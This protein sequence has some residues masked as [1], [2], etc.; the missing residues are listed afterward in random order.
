M[1]LESEDK[2]DFSLG[3]GPPRPKENDG[4][5]ES[6]VAAAEGMIEAFKSGNAKQLARML[7]ESRKD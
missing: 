2:L 4:P 6:E 5:S 3:F 1:A 7:K